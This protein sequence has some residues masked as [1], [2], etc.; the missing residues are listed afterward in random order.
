M[1]LIASPYNSYLYSWI[2][3]LIIYLTSLILF[4]WNLTSLILSPL[5]EFV[6][7]QAGSRL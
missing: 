2:E 4:F 6:L 7:Q 3:T 5:L 1:Y